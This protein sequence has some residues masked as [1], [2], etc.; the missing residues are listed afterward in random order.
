MPYIETNLENIINIKKNVIFIIH[1]NEA[2][3][4]GGQKIFMKESHDFWEFEYVLEGSLKIRHEKNVY[5]LSAGDILFHKP[6]QMH[7]S[8]PLSA[9]EG[10]KLANISF[11]CS[12]GAMKCFED[13]C[14]PLSGKS[15]QLLESVIE[16]GERNFIA[17]A[18]GPVARSVLKPDAPLGGQQAYKIQLEMF[19]INLIGEIHEQSPEKIFTS[20]TEFYRDIHNKIV[21][22]LTDNIYSDITLDDL[23]KKFN[24]SKAFLCKNFKKESGISI[25]NCYND[26]K[27]REAAALLKDKEHSVCYVAEVLHFSDRYYFSK[28]FKKTMGMSPAE[29]KK[30]ILKK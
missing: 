2:V 29:Y 24:F 13:Y 18:D 15:K 4:N 28:A 17:V 23:C 11:V 1:K 22:Y 16:E 26:L 14:A 3:K 9:S 30:S 7:Q 21:T 10:S 6:N 25:M 8:F 5:T 19:L 27:M 20:K 12:S